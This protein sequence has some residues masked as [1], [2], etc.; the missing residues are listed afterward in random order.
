MVG[1]DLT[2]TPIDRLG[3]FF[4]SGTAVAGV[5][6]DSEVAIRS[7]GIVAGG[8]DDAAEGAAFAD[9]AG[10]RRCGEDTVLSHQNLPEAVGRRHFQYDLDGFT[11]VEAAV[12]AHHQGLALIAR[13]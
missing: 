12:A 9:D 4:R 3:E 5:V 6:F 10:C 8:E 13:Q 1:T 2:A 7:A 11:V